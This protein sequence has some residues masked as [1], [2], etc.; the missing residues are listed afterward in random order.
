MLVL[1]ALPDAQ[2]HRL[3]RA[4]PPRFPVV[5][6]R[7]WDDALTTIRRRPVDLAV[8]DPL[9]AGAANAAEIERLRRCFPSLPLT[10]YTTLSPTTAAVLLLL[11]GAGIRHILFT[12]FDDHPARLR[13]VLVRDEARSVS[14]QL[15]EQLGTVLAPLPARLR[16]ALKDALQAPAGRRTVQ[17]VAARA[18]LDRRT[19]ERWSLRLGLPS[20]RHLLAAARVLHAHRLLQDPGFTVKD[21]AQRLGYAQTKTLQSH[22]RHYLGLTLGEMRSALEPA[23]ALERVAR[24]FLPQPVQATAS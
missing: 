3:R 16:W 7:S 21:V 9:L 14:R 19:F 1:G 4:A 6:A 8:V 17:Q 23:V 15:G 12:R 24:G 22:A 18:R 20:P 5:Q 13:E 11:G 2:F 10:L